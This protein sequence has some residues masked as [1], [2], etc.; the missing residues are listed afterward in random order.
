MKPGTA[1]RIWLALVGLTLAGAWLAERGEAGTPLT[2]MVAALIGVKGRAVID[3]YMEL[4][5]A[6]PTIRRILYT[7][8]AVV[9]TLVVATHWFGDVIARLTTVG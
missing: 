3:Y 5:D 2:L 1:E 7:F 4:R 9:V 6:N 8:N